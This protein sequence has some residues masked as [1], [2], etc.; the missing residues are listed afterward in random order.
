M[1]TDNAN[2]FDW[3][4][5]L[6]ASRDLSRSEKSGFEIF[7]Q[8]Y[9]SWRMPKA[10][11]PGRESAK[12]FWRAQVLS[13][14]RE[15][16]QLDQWAAAMRWYLHWLS[17]CQAKGGSGLCVE[18]RVRQAV[19][20]AGARRGLALRTR[21]AYA[22]WA[23]RFA[24]W[25]GDERSATDEAKARD[26]LARLVTEEKVSFSTQ[27]QA[28]NSLAF[29]F[30][31]VCGREEINL[32]VT[33]RRTARRVPV[34]L[35]LAEIAAMLER[36]PEHCRLA[37]EL[38]YGSGLRLAE[39]LN[40]RI[41]DVDLDRGQV[42]VRA[43][44]GDKDR[45]T[46]LP[47]RVAEQ[48]ALRKTSLRDL[49]EADRAAGVPGVALPSALARK[50]PKAGESWEWFWLFPASGLSTDP[51][52]GIRRRHHLHP[53]VYAEAIRRAAREAGIEKRVTTH[54]LRHSFATHLLECG[55]DIRTLQELLG[56]AELDT[57]M[58]Y[59]HVAQNLGA[60]GVRSPLDG[61]G[62][63]AGPAPADLR[64]A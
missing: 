32:Q 13:K 7:L 44:K 20:R 50:F 60:C 25:A 47:Q 62:L 56:H 46:V 64:A 30:R 54:A 17:C 43:G 35:S 58:I 59:T 37:A 24:R 52:S 2:K 51:D 55:T 34:V 16:W 39:L 27:K 36:L 21:R 6:S 5:D 1:N 61:F 9:E 23:G 57:T 28:L 48:L 26:W 15:P 49:H 11:V 42:T 19:D 18:E 29:F 3:R 14:P 45:V 8:W 41:K 63:G 40:L 33:M 4:A 10:L 22:S 38:Q 31:D 12:S 53:K